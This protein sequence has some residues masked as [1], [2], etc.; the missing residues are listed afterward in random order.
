MI[1]R[2]SGW[3]QV[4]PPRDHRGLCGWTPCVPARR[5]TGTAGRTGTERRNVARL[6]HWI[7][8]VWCCRPCSR[9]SPS[10]S[11]PR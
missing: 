3:E 7:T 2:R 10:C 1:L 11:C 8:R 9:C 4:R 5:Y 6:P